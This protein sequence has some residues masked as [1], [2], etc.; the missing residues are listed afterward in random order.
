MRRRGEPWFLTE[1]RCEAGSS[2]TKY[3]LADRHCAVR[4]DNI[5]SAID[6][7]FDCRFRRADAIASVT[8]LAGRAYQWCCPRRFFAIK[9]SPARD[10]AHGLGGMTHTSALNTRIDARSGQ[11]TRQ[12]VDAG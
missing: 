9:F 11:N 5:A 2:A 7:V 4:R 10:A 12:I 3:R 1:G 8:F 6:G